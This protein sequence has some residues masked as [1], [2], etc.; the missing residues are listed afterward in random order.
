MRAEQH[1][2][3]A[4]L[5]AAVALP[6]SGIDNASQ[7]ARDPLVQRRYSLPVRARASSR[8]VIPVDGQA[9]EYLGERAAVIAPAG[10][11]GR[12]V[13]GGAEELGQAG[14]DPDAQGRRGRGAALVEG[15][16]DGVEGLQAAQEGGGVD[17][18]DGRGEGEGVGGEVAGL[19]RAVGG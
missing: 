2:L 10:R 1:G 11:V 8:P 9:R 6:V 15:L 19:G 3:D 12:R 13:A 14:L 5:A 16:E 17:L 4:S 18:L 7:R